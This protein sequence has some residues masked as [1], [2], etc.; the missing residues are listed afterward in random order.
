MRRYAVNNRD[1]LIERLVYARAV[2]NI[3]IIVQRNRA[4]LDGRGLFQAVQERNRILPGIIADNNFAVVDFRTAGA[5]V[6]VPDRQVRVMVHGF[7]INQ[8]QLGGVLRRPCNI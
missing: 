3:R 1:I 4:N 8:H 6:H 7:Q 2:G 5:V